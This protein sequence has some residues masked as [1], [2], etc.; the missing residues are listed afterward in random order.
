MSQAAESSGAA[1]AKA[2][3]ADEEPFNPTE[4]E[5]K[6]ML[7]EHWRERIAGGSDALPEHDV[8]VN[9]KMR[10]VHRKKR[11]QAGHCHPM[12]DVAPPTFLQQY[13]A[14]PSSFECDFAGMGWGD[15]EED[16][17]SAAVD[18]QRLQTAAAK[19]ARS[20]LP[21]MRRYTDASLMPFGNGPFASERRQAWAATMKLVGQR[22]RDMFKQVQTF[23]MDAKKCVQMCQKRYRKD[24]LASLKAQRDFAVRA[25]KVSKDAG[26][27]WRREN[28]QKLAAEGRLDS[29]ALS[30]GDISKSR[31]E[32]REVMERKRMEEAERER[33]RQQKRINFLLTQTELFA[34]FIGQKMGGI[35]EDKGSEDASDLQPVP[36][37]PEGEA[38]GGAKSKEAQM[39]AAA[40]E[41]GKLDKTETR[42]ALASAQAALKQR[43]NAMHSF[44][45]ETREAT[46]NKGL[47][48]KESAALAGSLDDAALQHTDVNVTAETAS[49]FTG[50][51]KSY[52]KIG[53]NWLVGLYEQ[54]LNGILA[55]EMG[56]GKTV[57]T[58]AL[59]THLSE[60]KGIWGPFLVVAPTST[61]HN[62]YSELQKFCPQMKVIPYF[63][64]NPNE[65]K[66]LRRMWTNPVDLGT[67]D[68]AFHVLV[69]NYKL[70]I[71]DEKHFARVQWQYMV[72]DEAQAVK[73][74]A[75]QRWKTLLGFN[76]RNR[77]L[78]TGTP[79]QNSMAELW[80]LLHFIMPELFDSFSDFTEWFSKDIESS[81][82]GDGKGLDAAQLKRLQLILQPFMLRRTKKDVLDELVQKVEIE[83]RTPLSTRQRYYYDVLKNRVKATATSTELSKDEKRLH[84]LMNLVMQF[85]KV[86]N[87]PEIFERRDFVSPLQ[88][89]QYVLPALPPPPTDMVV[90]N[91][92]NHS[93]ISLHLPALVYDDVA[94]RA[95]WCLLN[96]G[97]RTRILTT[98]LSPWA[99]DALHRSFFPSSC[100]APPPAA[101]EYS[102]M[103]RKGAAFAA[104]AAAAA[105]ARRHAQL[106]HERGGGL[107]CVR[108]SGL[109]EGEAAFLAWASPA[110]RWLASLALLSREVARRAVAVYEDDECKG[111][112]AAGIVGKAGRAE[113]GMPG[114]RSRK[115]PDIVLPWRAG[116]MEREWEGELVASASR[117]LHDMAPVLHV[118]RA[119]TTTP[120]A[121]PARIECSR[122]V[123]MRR[124]AEA[125]ED[126]WTRRLLLGGFASGDS[127]LS[128]Q[129][130]LSCAYLAPHSL[131]T[132]PA[133]W[134]AWPS[135]MQSLH[136]RIGS[137]SIRKPDMSKLVSDSGKLRLLDS[138]LPKLKAGR[139][140][141]C[142]SLAPTFPR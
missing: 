68:A 123:C 53:F 2:A 32:A 1:A 10:A 67:P 9:A 138:I 125:L 70:I 130:A 57:Q 121:A 35:T 93:T 41:K 110:Q 25:R 107:S 135:L 44:D 82:S 60:S 11:K 84:S 13:Q 102:G 46:K 64:A 61:M 37:A 127:P 7:L 90:V 83:M 19:K 119:L 89:S 31:R 106:V 77:L 99:V 80:A 36:A 78:L 27:I 134:P 103:R 81:A 15:G 142:L 3:E 58:I 118:T 109:S 88:I 33:V 34:H 128:W 129:N 71:A 14:D 105:A 98:L 65:R 79:I 16:E 38:A 137:N 50:T 40:K 51:L 63:G 56:L 131:Q 29:S 5:Y 45:E 114:W 104:A 54:G 92:V 76:C 26:T 21:L 28:A 20:S 18:S 85:R 47:S 59:L 100:P 101:E 120:Q 111:A 55:D 6:L 49:I 97:S 133:P 17:D 86:C 126:A 112:G 62:W 108:L 136:A 39:M 73:N 52:Q 8:G 30:S 48:K 124:Q 94:A 139:H 75:S 43:Q 113:V 69:T 140:K 22:Y 132:I 72:L 122:R 117:R 42:E 74:S 96:A 116:D 23:Q 91:V 87:H 115:L 24:A 141:V 95:D 66:L 4:S 12:F